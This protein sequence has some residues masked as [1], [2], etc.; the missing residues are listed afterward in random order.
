MP[1]IKEQ[2]SRVIWKCDGRRWVLSASVWEI[3]APPYS[4]LCPQRLEEFKVNP[5]SFSPAVST[6]SQFIL[7]VHF[8][9][10]MVWLWSVWCGCGR[11]AFDHLTVEGQTLVVLQTDRQPGWLSDIQWQTQQT[12]SAQCAP[13]A[14]PP[15]TLQ[16]A[17]DLL[18][19]WFPKWCINYKYLRLQLSGLLMG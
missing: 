17:K 19:L 15:L 1:S 13:T 6:T 16:E 5:L 9:Q 7:P 12:I 14:P 10:F 4:Y 11:C 2:I 3:Y 8:T 18:M